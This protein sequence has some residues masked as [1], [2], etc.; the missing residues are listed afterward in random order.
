MS[1]SQGEDLDL[2]LTAVHLAVRIV[3]VLRQLPRVELL[4]AP[5]LQQPRRL[6]VLRKQSSSVRLLRAGRN[7]FFLPVHG[8]W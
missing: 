6:L 2:G 5:V 4:L 3:H 1:L 8:G 7:R